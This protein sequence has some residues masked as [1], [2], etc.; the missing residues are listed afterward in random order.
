MQ[1]TRGAVARALAP[2]LLVLV[3]GGA[4]KAA[5]TFSGVV[6]DSECDSADHSGMRMGD[7]DAA[8]VKACI[9][10]HG[11]SYVLRAGNRTYALS[12]QRKP[13]AFAGRRVTV[14]GTL[15][16]G[17]KTIQLDSIAAQ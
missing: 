1:W 9:E 10:S 11:A 13:Q 4:P 12:D 6:T 5:Q 17:G 3:T 14:T 7:T 2:A 8:C 15:D 16:A